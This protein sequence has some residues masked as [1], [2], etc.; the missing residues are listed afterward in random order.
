MN[1]RPSPRLTFGP[2]RD[3]NEWRNLSSEKLRHF[4]FSPYIS[5]VIKSMIMRWAGQIAR[6]GEKTKAHKIST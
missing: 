2:E 5:T 1:K 3:E 6:V 4:C